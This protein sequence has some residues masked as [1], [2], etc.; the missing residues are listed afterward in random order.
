[1]VVWPEAA[2]FCCVAFTDGVVVPAG[3]GV[4]PLAGAAADCVAAGAA[5][6]P[7]ADAG[8]TAGSKAAAGAAAR[9]T[10]IKLRIVTD[11]SVLPDLFGA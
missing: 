4:A 8:A 1:V 7:K 6:C 10:F 5:A 11:M 2:A 9:S 3:A